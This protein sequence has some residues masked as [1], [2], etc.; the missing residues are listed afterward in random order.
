MPSAYLKDFK[1]EL[2]RVG[3]VVFKGRHRTPMLIVIG[4]AAELV[5]D[6]QR[7]D[8]TM[9]AA[10]SGPSKQATALVDRVFTVNKAPHAQ[11]GPIVLGRSADN[12]IAIPEYSISKRQCLFEFEPDGIKITDCGSTNGTIVE[13]DRI[14]AREPVTIKDGT[15]ISLGRFEF[16]FHTAAGFHAYVK[17][18]LP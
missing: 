13:K 12:D 17:S 14:P 3:D 7:G 16:V 2:R 6:S 10:P 1:E 8:K 5:D 15:K 4:K 18:L 9:V 11:R